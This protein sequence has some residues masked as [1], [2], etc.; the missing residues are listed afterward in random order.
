MVTF[1]GTL[2]YLSFSIVWDKWYWLYAMLS[3]SLT[4]L[5]VLFL[6]SF[7]RTTASRVTFILGFNRLVY[8]NTL[9]VGPNVAGNNYLFISL[10]MPFLIFD[11]KKVWLILMGIIIPIA[12]IYSFDF[13]VPFFSMPTLMAF[14]NGLV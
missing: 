6:N 12:L 3:L 14:T 2:V 4:C 7:G 11:I 10:I 5:G 8:L 1:L 9:F 13:V